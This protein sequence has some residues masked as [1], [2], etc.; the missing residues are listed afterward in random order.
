MFCYNLGGFKEMKTPTLTHRGIK[1][2]GTRQS[3]EDGFKA[4]QLSERNSILEWI[5]NQRDNRNMQGGFSSALCLSQLMKDL[6]KSKI[7]KSA[8]DF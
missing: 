5:E 1:R 4:G 2:D 7:T 8:G 6:E 3:I